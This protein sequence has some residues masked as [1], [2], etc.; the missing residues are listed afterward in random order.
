MKLSN[1]RLN[2]NLIEERLSLGYL[3]FLDKKDFS[4]EN[5]EAQ[6]ACGNCKCSQVEQSTLDEN[7][8]LYEFIENNIRNEEYRNALYSL[9][10]KSLWNYIENN[11]ILRLHLVTK[12]LVML[13]VKH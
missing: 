2:N 9:Y 7:E 11:R 10:R 3:K 12:S 6:A 1:L 4:K 5:T 13:F 8:H